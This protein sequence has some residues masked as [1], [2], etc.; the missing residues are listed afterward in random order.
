[1]TRWTLVIPEETN[2]ML[3]SH[4]ALRGTKKGDLSKFVDKAVRQ[5]LFRETMQDI[6]DRN[7]GI[8]QNLIEATIAEAVN[9]ARKTRS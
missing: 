2:Q 5:T 7:A 3:R 8:G 1:M 4:L 9:W 6:K